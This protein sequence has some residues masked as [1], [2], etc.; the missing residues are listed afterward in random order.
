MA[1]L[2]KGIKDFWLK[3]MEAI[4]NTA[5][6]IANNTKYKVNEMNMVNRRREILGDFGAKAYEL[7]QKGVE[8]PEELELQLQELSMLDIQLNEL[9]MEK[10]SNV[11]ARHEE[12]APEEMENTADVDS[13]VEVSVKEN[14]PDEI[15]VII[16]GDDTSASTEQ[17]PLS[18]AINNLFEE[19]PPVS[20]MAGKV[21]QSLDS[22][23]ASLRQI[24]SVNAESS[25]K[26]ES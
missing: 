12:N 17:C 6:N 3:S 8:F 23:G 26:T 2:G 4:G 7:W 15:P 19:T 14:E 5:S 9:R 25:E 20:E 21:N 18:D 22:F 24:E 10:L 13:V 11:E 1:D 16:N